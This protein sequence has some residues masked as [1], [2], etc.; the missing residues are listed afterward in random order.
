MEPTIA[1]LIGGNSSEG[2][3]NDTP[4]ESFT[5]AT[6]PPG[7]IAANYRAAI[8]VW[9][10]TLQIT[11]AVIGLIGNGFSLLVYMKVPGG[12]IHILLRVLATCDIGFLLILIHNSAIR[13][14]QFVNNYS[15]SWIVCYIISLLLWAFPA[16]ATYTTI[17]IAAERLMAVAFPLKAR[18]ICTPRRTRIAAALICIACLIGRLPNVLMSTVAQVVLPNGL[19]TY[20]IRR[21]PLFYQ[22]IGAYLLLAMAIIFDYIPPL[23]MVIFNLTILISLKRQDHKRQNLSES[24]QDQGKRLA[25]R[26][27]TI[28]LVA[29]GTMS[30][31][32]NAPLTLVRVIPLPRVVTL[33]LQIAFNTLYIVDHCANFF[34]YVIINKEFRKTFFELFKTSKS[35]S[36]LYRNNSTQGTSASSV[37]QDKSSVIDTASEKVDA[38]MEKNKA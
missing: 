6:L 23:L 21:G 35:R 20:T 4:I 9:Q 27:L 18:T 16:A 22:P 31:I 25:D 34:L 24:A 3:F 32:C 37:P 14:V 8:P 5:N 17:A 7:G 38:K 11:L 36:H 10:Y 13:Y 12:S 2:F 19:S 29:L 26:R 1:T 30:I 33:V 28:M 15:Y